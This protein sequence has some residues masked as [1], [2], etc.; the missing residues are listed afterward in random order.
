MQ[1]WMF[2]AERSR[3]SKTIC[4]T[5]FNINN[6]LR[7]ACRSIICAPGIGYAERKQVLFWRRLSLSACLCVNECHCLCNS[8]KYL[9]QIDIRNLVRMCVIVSRRRDSTTTFDLMSYFLIFS[10]TTPCLRDVV[11]P[12]SKRRQGVC[13]FQTGTVGSIFDTRSKQNDANNG[14]YAFQAHSNHSDAASC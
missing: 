9:S 13:V 5:S 3:G 11:S 10:D 1:L 8:W 14:H 7:Y 2:Y 12:C 6:V 4:P